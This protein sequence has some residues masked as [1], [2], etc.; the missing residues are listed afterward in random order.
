MK[1]YPSI[2]SANPLN[3]SGELEK[4][5]GH[6]HV[7]VDIEDGHFLPN[8][9]FGQKTVR[10]LVQQTDFEFDLHLLTDQPYLFLQTL[11]GCHFS[12]ICF[13]G[14]ASAYPLREINLIK[15]MGAKAGI[16]VNF[17]TQVREFRPF[18]PSLDYILIMTAEPDEA[19]ENFCPA[20]IE[21]IQEAR[22]ILPK[23]IEIWAD[24][25]IQAE[26]IRSLSETGVTAVVMGRAVWNSADPLQSLKEYEKL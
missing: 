15:K 23:N 12:H 22:A 6:P 9:T 4:I 24:G 2:A 18:F 1:V 19:G 26:N 25:G 16:A 7:H 11:S 14:E 20:M 5:R 13:H 17:K 8:I 21:K 10:Q 3:I